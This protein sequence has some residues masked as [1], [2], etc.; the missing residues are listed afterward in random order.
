VQTTLTA[1]IDEALEA[2]LSRLEVATGRSRDSLVAEALRGFVESEEAFVAA[3][4]AGRDDIAAGR[5]VDHATVV[6]SFERIVGRR[7]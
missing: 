4:E 2:R 3:I 1:K 6:E 7:R 5:T